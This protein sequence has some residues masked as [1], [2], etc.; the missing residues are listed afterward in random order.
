VKSSTIGRTNLLKVV[1]RPLGGKITIDY[2]RSGNTY[3]N[4]HHKW[5]LGE[6]EVFDGHVGDGADTM[7]QKFTYEDGYYDRHEREFYGFAWVTS[8][9]I[10]TTNG[11]AVYRKNVSH[12]INDNYYEKGLLDYSKVVDGADKLY[13]EKHNAYNTINIF[14]DDVLTDEQKKEDDHVTFSKLVQAQT[15]YYE[16]TDEAGQTTAIEYDYDQY[17]NVI[18]QYD[19]GEFSDSSDDWSAMVTYSQNLANYIV[20]VPTTIK[21]YDDAGN[22]LRDREATV[23]DYG[24]V[25]QVRVNTGATTLVSDMNYDQ[26]GNLIGITYPPNHKGQRYAL[27]YTLDD[28]VH[29]YTTSM[30]DS[31]GY[32]ATAEYDYKFGAQ[33]SQTDINNQPITTTLDDKGRI[34]TITGPLEAGMGKATITHSYFPDAPTPYALTQHYD[35]GKTDTIDTVTFID[36]LM[37]VI[38]TKKDAA[39]DD[40]KD[41]IALD[42]MSVSG[43]VVFDSFGRTEATH[44]PVSEGLGSKGAFNYTIDDGIE[45]TRTVYDILDRKVLTTLPDRATLSNAYG[46]KSDRDGVVRFHTLSTDANGNTAESFKDVRERITSVLQHNPLVGQTDI[47][48]SYNYNA[49][50][51]L[52]Q[53]KDDKENLTQAIYD[54]AGR[55]THI[56]NPDTGWIESVYD[57]AGNVVQ[58]IT[59]NLRAEGK[60]INYVYDYTRLT[61]INYPNNTQNNIAYTYGNNPGVLNAGRITKITDASGERLFEYGKLGE[62][63][64]ETRTLFTYTSTEPKTYVTQYRYDTWNRLRELTY[65]DAEVLTHNYDSGGKLSSLQGVKGDFSYDYLKAMT[66]DKFGQRVFTKYANDTTATYSYE[67]DRRRLSNVIATDASRTFMDNHYSYDKMQNILGVSNSAAV[68]IGSSEFGGETSQS[69]NYDNLYQLKN[70]EGSWTARQGHQYRYNLEMGYDTIGR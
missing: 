2:D 6:V 9:D 10:N 62:T 66:Y 8:S 12:Y 52:L 58:K 50:N 31:F 42:G 45:P 13:V 35:E 49:V 63:T 59:D 22:L 1:N 7:K 43:H 60:A 53:V 33:T 14:T 18:A 67:E 34:E 20:S 24:A 48:T 65:P 47:W 19:Y 69:F 54:I 17:G 23:D 15:L 56:N 11:D 44:Y 41:G 61:N 57:D 27:S 4:P 32:T 28:V 5:V 64:K 21:I 25:T 38:Q 40:D 68:D 55:R 30:S 26:Y 29:T 16:G 39:I 36:G 46:F 70:A 37:R 51:E 3:E